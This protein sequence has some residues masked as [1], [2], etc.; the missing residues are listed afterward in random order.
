VSVC[1]CE[2]ERER[3]SIFSGPEMARRNPPESRH[4]AS[5]HT[6]SITTSEADRPDTPPAASALATDDLKAVTTEVVKRSLLARDS[7]ITAFTTVFS[8]CH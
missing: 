7:F 5:S 8:P 2:R 6:E 1:V 4:P 3:E